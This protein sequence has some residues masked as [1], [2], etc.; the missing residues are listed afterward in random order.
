MLIYV[1]LGPPELNP[2]VH[3]ISV[4]VEAAE[5]VSTRLCVQ[6]YHQADMPEALIRLIQTEFNES[7]RQVFMIPLPVRRPHFVPLVKTLTTVHFRAKSVSMSGSFKD[8]LPPQGEVYHQPIEYIAFEDMLGLQKW[9]THNFFRLAELSMNLCW[10]W[11]EIKQ[12]QK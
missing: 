2:D 8:P 10:A 3:D 7:F 6:A 1:I 12:G 4:L 9:E 5:E 11:A